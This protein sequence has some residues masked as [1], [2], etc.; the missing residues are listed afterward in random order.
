MIQACT[1]LVVSLV[2]RYCGSMAKVI[3]QGLATGLGA[4]LPLAFGQHISIYAALGSA[5]TVISF[6][7][8]IDVDNQEREAA[9]CAKENDIDNNNKK[10]E[11]TLVESAKGAPTAK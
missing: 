8:Y 9:R 1:G 10:K 3:A 5:I 7:G 4:A 6:A 2:L 11:K